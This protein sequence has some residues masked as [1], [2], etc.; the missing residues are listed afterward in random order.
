MGSVNEA[1]RDKAIR[2]A[3]E[4]GRYGAGLSARIVSLLNSADADILDRLAARLVQIEE[5]G[6]DI[7]PRTTEWTCPGK[8]ERRLL[9]RPP[10][11]RTARG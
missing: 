8:V 10:V 1:L 9:S 3:I 2:H 4:I 7:G 5:R 11:A 6:F